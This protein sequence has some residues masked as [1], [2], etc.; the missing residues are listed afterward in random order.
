VDYF[1]EFVAARGPALWRAA[2]LLTGDRSLAEDLMQTA[3]TKAWPHF[4]RVSRNGSFEAY[5]RRTMFTTYAGWRGRRWHGEIPTGDL[6]ETGRTDEAPDP[7]LLRALAELSPRQRAVVVLRFLEDRSVAETA[8]ALGVTEGT[9]KSQTRDALARLRVLLP[10]LDAVE[11][12][13]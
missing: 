12:L 8:D 7:D 11:A 2:W 13:S 6:P 4:D 5:V 9:V 10:D 1:A 3:L